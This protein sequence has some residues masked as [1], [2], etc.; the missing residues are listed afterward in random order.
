MGDFLPDLTL[1]LDMSVEEGMART[2]LRGDS[3][4]FEDEKMIFFQTIRDAYLQR[5]KKSNG[6]IKI[7]DAKPSPKLVQQAIKKELELCL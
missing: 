6:R 7:I 2:R 5:A 3:D 4:R 1:L